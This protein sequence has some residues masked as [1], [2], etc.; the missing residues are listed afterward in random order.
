MLT[1]LSNTQEALL[2]YVKARIDSICQGKA[3]Q[4]LHPAAAGLTE[5]ADT[6]YNDIRACLNHLASSGDY[7]I[8]RTLNSATIRPCNAPSQ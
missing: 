7:S 6:V 8:S 5:I 1:R 3:S 4:G 2:P